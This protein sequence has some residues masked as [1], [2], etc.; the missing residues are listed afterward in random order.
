[1]NNNDKLLHLLQGEEQLQKLMPDYLQKLKQQTQQRQQSRL[2]VKQAQ[3]QLQ[4]LQRQIKQ[5]LKK[6]AR[7][8]HQVQQQ[9]QLM[10]QQATSLEQQYWARYHQP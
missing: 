8:N 10:Q 1:M 4:N 9:W 6:A 7:Q 2:L 5:Q 3:R